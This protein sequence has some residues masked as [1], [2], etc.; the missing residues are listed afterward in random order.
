M[1]AERF[2][3]TVGD[4]VEA[5]RWTGDNTRDVALWAEP[6]LAPYALPEGW[7]LRQHIA[8]TGNYFT[9]V[10]PCRGSEQDARVGDWIVKQASG[11]LPVAP[12]VVRQ[13]YTKI[14]EGV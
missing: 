2:V 1:T 7:W 14:P 9:L 5:M 10:L 4:T 12:Y 6:T 11:F 3:N 8:P 13:L